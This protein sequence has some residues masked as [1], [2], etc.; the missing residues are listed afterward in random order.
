M[1]ILSAFKKAWLGIKVSDQNDKRTRYIMTLWSFF[2]LSFLM[3]ACFVAAILVEN[4]DIKLAWIDMIKHL[5]YVFGG[6]LA[7]FFGMESFFPSEA[8]NYS[9]WGGWGKRDIENEPATHPSQGD[10]EV[11]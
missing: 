5:A 11:D 6:V 8:R 7:T 2:L 10:A 1:G 9:G 4:V 3:T